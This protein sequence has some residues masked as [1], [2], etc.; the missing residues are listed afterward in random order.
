MNNHIRHENNHILF[1][2]F[3]LKIMLETKT[4]DL[5]LIHPLIHHLEVSSWAN[6]KLLTQRLLLMISKSNIWFKAITFYITNSYITV[7]I[8]G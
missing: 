1:E 8:T 2:I 6:L 4:R 3:L 5:C 7:Y